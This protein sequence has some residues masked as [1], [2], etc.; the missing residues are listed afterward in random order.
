MK[1]KSNNFSR[2]LRNL[3]ILTGLRQ[4]I[5]AYRA[6]VSI[7]MVRQWESGAK[8]PNVEQFKVIA[9]FFGL[10]YTWFLDGRDIAPPDM[11]VSLGLSEDTVC[12][13]MELAA[14]ESGE[15]PDALDDAVYAVATV[16]NAVYDDLLRVAEESARKPAPSGTEG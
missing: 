6:G 3:F 12:L 7:E 15:V 13:L 2:R 16:V 11:A 14:S 8:L 5:L 9:S 10:P 4:E 1:R